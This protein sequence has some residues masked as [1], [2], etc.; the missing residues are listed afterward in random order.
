M[1]IVGP[2]SEEEMVAIYLQAETES[3]RFGPALHRILARD[4]VK[5][6]IVDTPN[7][8]DPDENAYRLR[9]LGESHGYRQN[10]TYYEG[11]PENIVWQRALLTSEELLHVKYMVL[12]YWNDLSNG[13]RSPLEAAKTIRTGRPVWGMATD[14]YLQMA[15]AVRKGVR[16]P[17]L[18]L[19]A[20]GEAMD[21]VVFEGHARLTA[22]ALAPEA[23][24]SE[25]MVILG[26]SPQMG[27]WVVLREDSASTHL[28]PGL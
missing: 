13:T 14:W 4:G 25:V 28:E 18:I 2:S 17:E 8:M 24:P 9:L 11:F 27:L 19:V 12:S 10:L 16:Y 23:I 26:T 22:Y 7:L 15:D 21:L 6:T 1:R 20:V 3:S 5:R